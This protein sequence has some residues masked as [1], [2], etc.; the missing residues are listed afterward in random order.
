L[1]L[2]FNDYY[3]YDYVGLDNNKVGVAGDSAGG[4]IAS[5]ISNEFKDLKG[6]SLKY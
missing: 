6:F 5:I 3:I 2:K 4:N 1:N